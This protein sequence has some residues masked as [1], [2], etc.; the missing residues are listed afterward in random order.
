[1]IESPYRAIVHPTVAYVESL[2]AQLPDL[3]LTVVVPELAVPHWWQRYL[4]DGDAARLR[5]ALRP[6]DKVVVTSVPFH[7]VTG[8]RG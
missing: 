5:R 7:R 6:L 4:H 2:H 8:A 1:V 3:T